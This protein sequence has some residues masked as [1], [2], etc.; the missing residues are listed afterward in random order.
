MQKCISIL[1]ET[2]HGDQNLTVTPTVHSLGRY[3]AAQEKINHSFACQP[4]NAAPNT[5][6]QLC[7]QCRADVFRTTFPAPGTGLLEGLAAKTG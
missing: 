6:R 1:H 3:A 4:C 5:R 7:S 2:V